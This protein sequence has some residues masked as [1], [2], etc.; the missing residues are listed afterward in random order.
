MKRLLIS[1]SVAL[2]VLAGVALANPGKPTF[3]PVIY[4]D[5][6]VWGTK[7][8]TTLPAPNGNNEQS[9]DKLFVIVNGAPGQLPVG[10]AAPGN[11]AY[12]GGRW[13]THTAM[14]TAEGMAAHDPLP[15]LM[16]YA[17]IQLHEKLG[18]VGAKR[19]E[20]PGQ[21]NRHDELLYHR[22]KKRRDGDYHQCQHGFA[23]GVLIHRGNSTGQRRA[24]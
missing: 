3:G 12:N 16:S 11:P 21:E 22:E 8:V 4:A 20:Q 13:F 18:H 10:E 23:H 1:I 24:V 5:G 15:V 9:F 19:A 17:D 6:E 2:L 14:W 7:A